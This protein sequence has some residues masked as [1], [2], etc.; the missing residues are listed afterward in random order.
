MDKILASPEQAVADIADGAT[1]TIA[2][3]GVA[4]RF[5]TALICALRDQRTRNLTLVDPRTTY[6]EICL[7]M[8]AWPN[9]PARSVHDD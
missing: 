3:F 5:A 2:G 8:K 6:R 4:H 7:M 1:V 9:S